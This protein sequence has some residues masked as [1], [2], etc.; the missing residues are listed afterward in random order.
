MLSSPIMTDTHTDMRYKSTLRTLA[1]NE[2]GIR[3]DS[4]PKT[5]RYGIQVARHLGVNF[6]WVDSLCIDQHDAEELAREIANMSSYYRNYLLTISATAARSCAEG[7][8]N[9]ASDPNPASLGGF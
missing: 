1:R 6:L 7:F 9:S 8:L 2:P 5:I 3:I 4:L